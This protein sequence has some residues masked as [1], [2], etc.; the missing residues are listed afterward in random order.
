M[1]ALPVQVAVLHSSKAVPVVAEYAV[2]G[3]TYAPEGT[4]SDS[5]TDLKVVFLFIA[6]VLNFI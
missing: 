1:L 2:S 6:W 3:T 5:T 4:I